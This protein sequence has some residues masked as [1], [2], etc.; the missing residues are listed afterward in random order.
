VPTY[1]HADFTPTE[2]VTA[3]SDLVLWVRY[4]IKPTP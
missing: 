3:F 2:L 1:G 4:G